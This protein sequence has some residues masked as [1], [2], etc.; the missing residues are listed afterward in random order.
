T[1]WP[2]TSKWLGSLMVWPE[3]S[4]AAK[5]SKDSA[6]PPDGVMVC[7]VDVAVGVMAMALER[8]GGG[9]RA[10]GSA[11]KMCEFSPWVRR[12]AAVLA[13]PPLLYVTSSAVLRLSFDPN[14]MVWFVPLTPLFESN[15]SALPPS[16]VMVCV[17]DAAVGVM[18]MALVLDGSAASSMWSAS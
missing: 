8:G 10:L 7:M 3:G 4:T 15:D 11:S 14:L 18:A 5:E 17:L 2:V 13:L 1:S 6:L 16:G 12:A 9:A